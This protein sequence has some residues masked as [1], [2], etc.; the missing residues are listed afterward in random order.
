VD[1]SGINPTTLQLLPKAAGGS[2]VTTTCNFP[3]TR[4][5]GKPAP[6][7]QGNPF[8]LAVVKLNPSSGQDEGATQAEATHGGTPAN[9]SSSKAK[10]DFLFAFGWDQSFPSGASVIAHLNPAWRGAIALHTLQ[11]SLGSAQ[12]SAHFYAGSGFYDK[13]LSQYVNKQAYANITKSV[14]STVKKKWIFNHPAETADKTFGI[15]LTPGHVYYFY[16]YSSA[17]VSVSTD[18]GAPAA[19]AIDFGSKYLDTP[20]TIF[21]SDGSKVSGFDRPGTNSSNKVQ[22]VFKVPN[23]GV[24]C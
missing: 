21:K 8:A 9:V 22:L 6:P 5:T 16:S 1:L 24:S 7:A 18:Y 3:F 19:A 23:V 4:K 2:I 11:T 17:Q 12:A 10:S 15:D 20:A 14:S 13:T